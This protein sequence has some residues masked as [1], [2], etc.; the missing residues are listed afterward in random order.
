MLSAKFHEV[1]QKPY[2]KVNQRMSFR[3]RPESRSFPG[4][5]Y[6]VVDPLPRKRPPSGRRGYSRAKKF[7]RK[8]RLEI[9]LIPGLSF[10]V[11]EVFA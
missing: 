1:K 5:L 4:F 6:E 9:A 10:A 3:R 11:R 7:S 8:D 2:V